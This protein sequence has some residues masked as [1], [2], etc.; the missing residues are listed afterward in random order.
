M[1]FPLLRVR[2][3]NSK[4]PHTWGYFFHIP[5]VTNKN[6]NMEFPSN[7][8][9]KVWL[10]SIKADTRKK[11]EQYINLFLQ[12]SG[13]IDVNNV[14]DKFR[15]FIV[16]KHEERY[17]STT[18]WTIYS[19]ISK[20]IKIQF[21]IDADKDEKIISKLIQ[22]WSKNETV[23]KSKVNCDNFHGTLYL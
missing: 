17:H 10:S 11:Y 15:S 1:N 9:V 6:V 21:N 7:E 23:K 3:R 20:Y 13:V 22:Q 12:Y 14:K 2:D 18:L 19:T 16:T 5:T 8:N 4:Y